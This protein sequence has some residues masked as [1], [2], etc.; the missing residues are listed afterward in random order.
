MPWKIHE[1]KLKSWTWT[2]EVGTSSKLASGLDHQSAATTRSDW[3][4]GIATTFAVRQVG[5]GREVSKIPNQHITEVFMNKQPWL[6]FVSTS[7]IPI[8]A[9]HYV[10]AISLCSRSGAWVQALAALALCKPLATAI[11]FNAAMAACAKGSQ[12]RFALALLQ[13]IISFCLG[14]ALR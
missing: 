9:F 6:E 12:W 7:R 14:I 13:D 1:Q 8:H 2:C 5:F 4:F 11:T 3:S 10:Q